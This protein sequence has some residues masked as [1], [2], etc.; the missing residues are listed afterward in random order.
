MIFSLPNFKNFAKEHTATFVAGIIFVLVIA[1]A[2]YAFLTAK[3]DYNVL[4]EALYNGNYLQVIESAEKFLAKNPEDLALIHLLA[5][6]YLSEA[7]VTGSPVWQN[8]SVAFLIDQM[9]KY[10]DDA[11]LL[12]LRGY[13]YFLVGAYDLAERFYQQS[14]NI[15][16]TNS[17]TWS[18]L[19]LL[20]ERK[21]NFL[22]ASSLYDKALAIDPND[23]IAN[24]GK[25]RNLF[26]GNKSAEARSSAAD[27]L[28]KT[29]DALTK[30]AIYEMLGLDAL[31]VN[32]YEKAEEYLNSALSLNPNLPISLASYALAMYSNIIRGPL[33]DLPTKL[34][35]PEALALEAI[36]IKPNYAFAYAVLSRI[37]KLKGDDQ[38]AKEY[39]A[40]VLSSLEYDDLTPKA[41]KVALKK[42]FDTTTPAISNIKIIS[43]KKA[44][45]S[46]LGPTASTTGI[47]IINKSRQ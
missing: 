46:S 12:R 39:G 16:Q 40:K 1:G 41:D 34:A 8:R 9:K 17:L 7:T 22:K 6:A 10:P 21:G 13:Y 25:I 31:S 38:K 18:S 24:V 37:A 4:Q 14:A 5:G 19:G 33:D 3:P 20:Y 15:D 30:A 32:N 29:K 44:D 35:K 2:M 47:I 43:I 42:S 28:L 45:A 36:A 26:R 11:E 23:Q 27:F